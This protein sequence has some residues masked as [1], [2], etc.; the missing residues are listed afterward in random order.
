MTTGLNPNIDPV[1][2]LVDN[3]K[4]D[5]NAAALISLHLRRLGVE[6]KLEPLE[7]YRAC[8]PA[9]RPSMVVINH[10]SGSHLVAWTKRLKELGVLVGMLSNEGMFLG[11]E[12]LRYG[13]GRHYESAHLDHIFCWNERHRQGLISEGAYKNSQMH[14]ISVPRFDFYFEPYASH[15]RNIGRSDRDRPEL[16]ACT[17]F[18]LA[19][20][21]DLPREAGDRFFAA[22]KTHI[23]GYE[24]YWEM[25]GAH[26]AARVVF[27]EHLRALLASR[28][29]GITLR[30]HPV[31]NIDFYHNW[32]NGLS[33]DERSRIR[34]EPDRNITSLI[35]GCDLEISGQSCTTAVETWIA[36][37]PTVELEFERNPA[38]Y[39]EERS[40]GNV[41]CNDPSK[42]VDI[43][44]AQLANPEQPQLR[45]V[46]DTYLEKWCG[47]PNGT[48]CERIA[49]IIHQ[50]VSTK[51]PADWSKLSTTDRRRA[52]KLHITRSVGLAYHFDPFLKFKRLLFGK[53]YEVREF[54]YEKSIK[55][56]DVAE[57]QRKLESMLS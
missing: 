32:L 8:V 18:G 7:S 23:A 2:L 4:R 29:F 56:A 3:R 48:S 37:K 55:P 49:Q 13:S 44:E 57:A 31:E 34:M 50:A 17:N 21:H 12:V 40:A 5:L 47:S 36:R 15:M 51:T 33:Q 52:A 25:I 10:V 38:L 20:F 30:P 43:V 11:K 27:T 1:V 35:L 14:V 54:S 42:I 41:H 22:W 26:A 9:Y 46:R 45:A 39:D 19:R 53:R 16:L 24:N 28:K 6:C